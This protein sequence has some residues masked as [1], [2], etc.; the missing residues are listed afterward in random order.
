MT[1]LLNIL[2]FSLFLLELL[3]GMLGDG[4]IAGLLGSEWIRCR[5]LPPCD[6]IVASLGASRFLLLWVAMLNGIYASIFPKFYECS[7]FFLFFNS[8]GAILSLVSFWLA[9]GLSIFYCVKISTFTH[10]LFLWLKQRISGLVPWFLTGSLLA[11]CVTIILITTGYSI[12][13]T[14]ENASG[15]CTEVEGKTSRSLYILSMTFIM[16]CVPFLLLLISSVLLTTSLRRHLKAMQHHGPGLQDCSTKAHTRALVMLASFLFCYALYFV[17]LIF[18]AALIIP[19]NSPWIWLIQMVTYLGPI[20][21]TFML[22]WSNPKIRGALER[23]GLQRVP[24][25]L[26]PCWMAY[27]SPSVSPG[28]PVIL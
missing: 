16:L 10:P 9:A 28:P 26:T 24:A 1:A 27:I 7:I 4:F 14:Q 19:F 5:K 11:S 25:C 12:I 8:L 3:V 21:H 6:M 18:I 13:L 2:F 17:S 22:I 20:S 15:N 23:G